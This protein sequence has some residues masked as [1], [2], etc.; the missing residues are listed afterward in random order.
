MM[1]TDGL[2]GDED[3][4]R[5]MTAPCQINAICL[6]ESA[7]ARC[8]GRLGIIPAKAAAEIVERIEKR[9]IDPADLLGPTMRAGIAAQAVAAALKKQC[10]ENADWVH[11]GATSQDIEDTA[12]VICLV[13]ALRIIEER[14][15][16]LEKRL[17]A[18]AERFAD[19]AI[20]A[21]TRFQLA[22]PTTLGAKIAVWRAPLRRHLKRLAEL[23]VRLFTV[24][25][26]GAAG[27]GAA[28][29]PDM[30][31]VRQA[32][33]E[34]LNL[35]ADDVPWHSARDNIAELAGWLAMLCGSLGKIGADLILLGQSEIAEVSAGTGGASSTM[36]Q[37]SNPIAAETLVT[38]ARLNAG[39]VGTIHQAMV[40]AQER[41][42]SALAI[43]W[44]VLPGMVVQSGAALH[45]AID[46]VESL[47]ADPKAI[48]GTF[49]ADRG[50]MLAEAA[51]FHLLRF[52]P[53]HKALEL[54]RQALAEMATNGGETLPE[55]LSRIVP[56]HDWAEILAIENNKGDAAGQARS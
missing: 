2:F 7:L 49:D 16:K 55:A 43:E 18:K 32:L 33:A 51:G 3:L 47:S 14:L 15:V 35:G 34:E 41:D 19:L 46:L 27:T 54:V 39:A 12:L 40:H 23:R 36:P 10:G 29:G 4:E 1:L 5:L 21:R 42:G 9:Q 31:R 20:P 37:K 56:G 50:A 52:M 8:Q 11:F 38:I 53:R 30:A 17:A 48:Q 13:E 6:V 25:F 24:S 45:L 44:R 26:H 22:A 28:L